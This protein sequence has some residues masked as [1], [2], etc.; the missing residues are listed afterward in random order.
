[1]GRPLFML[2]ASS[3][4]VGYRCRVLVQNRIM[5]CMLQ[6]YAR[7]LWVHKMNLYRWNES[8][9]RHKV[10]KK[11]NQRIPDGIWQ[12]FVDDRSVGQVR[13][14][15]EELDWLVSQIEKF[16]TAAELSGKAGAML[17]PVETP[18]R[19]R[20]NKVVSAGNDAVS[21]FIAAR[22]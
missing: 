14:N 16:L 7:F 12:Y 20:R 13:Q 10:E 18:R 19:Q 15:P 6:A 4:P 9:V 3:T 22:A 11:L 21:E 17:S 1:M 2:H 5:P 8:A